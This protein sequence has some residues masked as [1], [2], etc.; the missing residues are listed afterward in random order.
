MALAVQIGGCSIRQGC[1]VTALSWTA[2]HQPHN[3]TGDGS[4]E[5]GTAT[6]GSSHQPH[7]AAE[8][9][10]YMLL[11][12]GSSD[13]SVTLFGQT[14]SHLDTLQA[15]TVQHVTDPGSQATTALQPVQTVMHPDLRGVTCLHLQCLS[16][17]SGEHHIHAHV[18]AD[19][20]K[21]IGGAGIDIHI[22]QLT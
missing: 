1:W 14:A 15:M 9:G 2:G 10:S 3:C 17:A 19:D 7:A 6:T 21:G 8:G 5:P 18:P 22:H 4:D 16:S 13:G 12:C 11:A 20:W